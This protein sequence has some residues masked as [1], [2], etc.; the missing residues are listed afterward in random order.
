MSS[1]HD[2]SARPDAP[3]TGQESGASQYVPR[4]TPGYDN[5]AT[6]HARPSGAVIGWTVFA[7]TV[8]M[9]SGLWDFLIGLAAVIRGSFFVQMPDYAYNVSVRGWGWIHLILGVVVF[10]A[11]A[12]LLT[13]KFWARVVGV[14]LAVCSLIANFMYIPFSPVWS[15]V[16]IALDVFVIWALTAPRQ[17]TL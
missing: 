3:P 12:G 6:R 5:A 8:M 2:Q 15:I 1:A 14:T 11:G 17:H 13:G 9:V 16:V 10:L 4:P 7:A